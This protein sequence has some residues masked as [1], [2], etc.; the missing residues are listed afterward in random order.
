VLTFGKGLTA[1]GPL[2]NPRAMALPP[3]ELLA[4]KATFPARAAPGP[5][6][7]DDNGVPEPNAD[8]PNPEGA[9]PAELPNA[10]D[11]NVGA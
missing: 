7:L 10:D 3:R 6:A 1:Y 9:V 5:R 8:W 11:A 4:P 2:P